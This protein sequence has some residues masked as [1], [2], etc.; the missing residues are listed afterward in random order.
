MKRIKIK[1]GVKKFLKKTF[2]ISLI[3]SVG[4]VFSVSYAKATWLD[5]WYDNVMSSSSGVNYFEGQKRGY[6][7]FGSFSLRMPTRTD[8]L[9]SIEKPHLKIGCGGIDA[10]MGGFSFLNPDYLV[11]K[12]QAMLQAAPF[13]AFDIA[14]STL[15]PTCSE[16]LKKAEAIIDALN[17]IQISECGLYVPKTVVDLVKDPAGFFKSQGEKTA[18]V[19]SNLNISDLWNKFWNKFVHITGND[20]RTGDMTS[21]QALSGLSGHVRNWIE[22]SSESTGF[23]EY[24]A[25][26]GYVDRDVAEIFR[27]YVGEL[28]KSTNNQKTLVNLEYKKLCNEAD[29]SKILQNNGEIMRL[30]FGSRSCVSERITKTT[31]KIVNAIINAYYGITGKG[32]IPQD[33]KNIAQASPVP[34]HLFMKYAVMTKSPSILYSIS[35]AIAQGIVYSGL[36]DLSGKMNYVVNSL[37]YYY[38]SNFASNQTDPAGKELLAQLRDIQEKM[39]K[40]KTKFDERILGLYRNTVL[41]LTQGIQQAVLIMNFD[42][43]TK[44]TLGIQ[45]STLLTSLAEVKK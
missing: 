23:V 38:S 9:F 22:T 42:K 1:K 6:V 43:L 29:P 18:S 34:I 37:S 30:P 32:N 28:Y 3:S 16:I 15:C 21:F 4:L 41:D 5:N 44:E 26:N 14:L 33:Y 24:L 31:D 25:S 20:I 35:P 40:E 45:F 8:Y 7:T 2:G 12:V 17:Q 19:A 10:F 39:T 11:Q 27:A 36:L 13:I